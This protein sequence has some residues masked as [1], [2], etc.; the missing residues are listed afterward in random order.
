M[1]RYINEIRCFHQVVGLTFRY[2]PQT[3][4][5][6]VITLITEPVSGKS[7]PRLYYSSTKMFIVIFLR[8]MNPLKPQLL[9]QFYF[10]H[11][12]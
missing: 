1:F 10:F 6:A 11:L 12:I 3:D 5:M 4:K 2:S 7:V 9:G 8:I